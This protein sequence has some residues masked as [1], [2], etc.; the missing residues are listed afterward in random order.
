VANIVFPDAPLY[1]TAAYGEAAAEAKKHSQP[2]KALRN[3]KTAA[4][5]KGLFES[6][7]KSNVEKT[8]EFP[9]SE[10][11]TALL[12]DAV[13]NAGDTLLK[14]PLPG[15]IK[16]YKNAVRNFINYVVE[17]SYDKELVEGV[18]NWTLPEGKAK[19]PAKATSRKLFVKIQIVNEKLEALALG[20]LKGQ[21]EKL[22][23]L[24]RIEEINGLI[25]DLL[26]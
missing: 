25:V 7:F 3:E 11:S 8:T 21:H 15:E 5:K 19:D 23:L 13:H 17:N 10:E 24:G 26:E 22:A 14:H 6:F 9:F 4:P 1:N 16:Q 18:P 2:G 12:L 20:V